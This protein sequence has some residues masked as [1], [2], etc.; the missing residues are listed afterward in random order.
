MPLILSVPAMRLATL[1]LL[2]LFAAPPARA[3]A[4]KISPKGDPSVRSDTIY[5]LAVDPAGHSGESQVFLL[6]DGV[7]RLEA[8]GR[9]TSTFRQIV[10]ILT[11]AG[12]EAEQ[13]QSFGYSPAHEKLT[14]NWIRVVKPDGQVVNEKPSLVQEAD[15]PAGLGDPVYSDR[16]VIRA[17]LSGVA[18]GTLVDYSY[19]REELRPFHPGDFFQWWGVSTGLSVRRSRLVVDLPVTLTP[20]IVEQNLNFARQ[21]TVAKGRRVYLWAA[22][23][24]PRV[25]SEA[26][27]S[28]SNGVYMAVKVA[29]PMTW[30]DIAAWYSGLARDRYALTPRAAAIVDSLVAGAV[31]RV[32]TIRAIHRW[33]AQDIRYVSIALGLGGYQPRPPA[34]VIRTGFGDCKDKA[35]LFVAALTRLGITA[36]PVLLSADGGVDRRLPSIEQFDHAIAAVVEPGG[37]YRFV[38]LTASLVA[39]GQLPYGEQGEF[40]LVVRPDGTSDE[41]TLPLAPVTDNLS[42]TIISGTLSRD[43][44]FDGHYAERALGAR[45]GDLRDAFSAPLDSARRA[46]IQRGTATRIFTGARGD[47]LVAFDGLDLQ[48]E[49]RVTLAIRNGQAASISGPSRILKLPFKSMAGLAGLAD[50]L[51]SQGARRFPID[52]EEVIGGV[53]NLTDVRITLPE[54]WRARLPASVT[55]ESAFGSYVSS[56]LQEGRELRLSRRMTGARGVFPP[57]RIGELLAWFRAVGGDEAEFIVLDPDSR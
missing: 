37:G 31:S 17:S 55:A 52:A 16:R 22:Q 25:R 18:P 23:D 29:S 56:Y 5:R 32:D 7:V 27:A 12:A 51:E 8:D 46:N 43:G 15:V 48:A 34:E 50:R 38:D 36:Y 40:A 3:Q 26:Y 49:P 42:E 24:L 21:E 1:A 4:P 6:D 57:E 30:G 10:Q 44:I 14:I 2:M 13:E 47:S 11:Q 45:G 35:T 39:Y 54:G 9:G 33:V 28:D 20:R 19:T 41:V 53:S